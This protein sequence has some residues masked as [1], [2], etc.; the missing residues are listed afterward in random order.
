[1]ADDTN[2]T[3]TVFYSWQSDRPNSL[4][5]GFIQ[6][7]LERAA[8]AIRNDDSIEVDLVVDRDT[9]G[10]PGSPDISVTIFEKIDKC[11]AFV[12]DVTII[13]D[14]DEQ[15][16]RGPNPNVMVEL[17]YALKTL[18]WERVIIVMNTAFGEVGLL[19]FDLPRRRVTGYRLAEG[20][21]KAP[22]RNVLAK[23]FEGQLRS[24]LAAFESSE[25]PTKDSVEDLLAAIASGAP[26][27]DSQIRDY[28]TGLVEMLD[29]LAPPTTPEGHADDALVTSL[30][31]S[32]NLVVGFGKVV[33]AI[34]RHNNQPC[35]LALYSGFEA[36][37]ERYDMRTGGSFRTTDFDFFKFLGHELFVM[38]IAALMTHDRL[39]VVATVLK[40]ALAIRSIRKNA[41]D[42]AFHELSKQV[43]L[44][45]Q[46]KA[47]LQLRTMLLHSTVLQERHAGGHLV[48]VSPFRAFL[49]ADF[50]LWLRQELLPDHFPDG[51]RNTERW[52]PWS[53][54]FLN[55]KTPRFIVRAA[56]VRYAERLLPV[57]GLTDLNTFRQRY[58]ER[59]KRIDRLFRKENPFF[60]VDLPA[61][62]AIGTR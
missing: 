7:A 5:R 35:A 16:R 61:A 44:L 21:S 31:A 46:R 43:A 56:S 6:D 8:K 41:D 34:A 37:L 58:G 62:E 25:A 9:Q 15:G 30:E 52:V 18:G 45:E 50:L 39:E 36:I 47:R 48:A 40:E 26:D 4:N 13:H 3:F 55:E 32:L 51:S 24:I 27:V 12:A 14:G 57:L 22:V 38:L 42:L 2:P 53:G 11:Q 1:M 54:V 49:E 29:Q 60:E 19:P 59:A 20:D 23:Q 28:M 17:G 10:R 33:D